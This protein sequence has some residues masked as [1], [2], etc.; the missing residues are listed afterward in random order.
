[1][2]AHP[3]AAACKP[4]PT[5]PARVDPHAA[6]EMAILVNSSDGFQDCWSPFFSL[7]KAFWPDRTFPVYLNTETVPYSHTG[8]DIISLTHPPT[9]GGRRLPWSDRL[10]QSLEAIPQRYV[11]YMQEDYFLDAPVN[12]DIVSD[13]LMTLAEAELGCVHLTPFGSRRSKKVAERAYLVD[14]PRLSHYRVSTQAAIWDKHVLARYV[15]PNETVWETEIL[16]TVRAWSQPAGI[17][18]VDPARMG[19]APVISYTGTGI[20]RG[21]WH[22]AMVP[23]FARH[24]I[25]MDFNRRGFHRFPSRWETRYRILMA[26][27]ARPH[28]P[29]AALLGF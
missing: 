29:L 3:K 27:L 18:A 4:R 2:S 15:R 17:R 28:R 11:L 5:N 9:S 16:G 10:L 26:L 24:D 23:L 12:S 21:Q 22:P 6:A 25:V 13:S 20:I 1:M 8:L 19:G 7:L 14:V